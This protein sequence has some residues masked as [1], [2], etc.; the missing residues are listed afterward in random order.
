MTA[1]KATHTRIVTFRLRRLNSAPMPV[2]APVSP[3]VPDAG[4]LAWPVTSGSAWTGGWPTLRA[5]ALT[6][7]RAR[8]GRRL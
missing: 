5:I 8:A 2:S 4:P 7:S 3:S 1:K 6:F